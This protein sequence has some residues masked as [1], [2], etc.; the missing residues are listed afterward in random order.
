MSKVSK[1]Q[2]KK[3]KG[4]AEVILKFQAQAN[5]S[6]RCHFEGPVYLIHFRLA[7]LFDAN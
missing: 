2:K 7:K 4:G 1:N 5:P 6:A 3:K